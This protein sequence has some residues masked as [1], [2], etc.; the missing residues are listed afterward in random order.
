MYGQGHRN[1]A[2][3]STRTDGLPGVANRRGQSAGAG[4]RYALPE[5]WD[6]QVTVPG[7]V[8]ELLSEETRRAMAEHFSPVDHF[9]GVTKHLSDERLRE[10]IVHFV[11]AAQRETATKFLCDRAAMC[12]SEW[13]GRSLQGPQQRS[14][15]QAA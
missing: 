5:A 12:H 15:R 14:P 8:G 2:Y 4:K 11:Q 9:R 3:R 6:G 10:L 13:Y 1:R 7:V